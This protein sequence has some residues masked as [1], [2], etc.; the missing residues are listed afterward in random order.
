MKLRARYIYYEWKR[1]LRYI[2]QMFLGAIVLVFMT[3]TIAFCAVGTFSD[4][5]IKPTIPVGLVVHDNSSNISFLIDIISNMDS[6]KEHFRFLEMSLDEATAALSDGQICAIMILPN[7]VVSGIMDGTN[8][9]I[10]VILSKSDPLSSILLQEFATAGAKTL[11]SA[12]AGTYT[13]TDLYLDAGL[14]N[15]LSEAYAE[16]DIRNLQY[17]LVRD[18]LFRTVHAEPTGNVSTRSY[19][20]SSALIFFFLMLG[21]GCVIF[22]DKGSHAGIL[23]RSSAKIGTITERLANYLSILFY[24][25]LPAF[26]FAI[27]LMVSDFHTTLT[28]VE[29]ASILML[30][31]I[32]ILASSAYL[33]FLLELSTTPAI[34]VVTIFILSMLMM[35]ISGCFIP[36]GLLP[37]PLHCVS[38]VL[39]VWDMMRQWFHILSFMDGT[40]YQY[41]T[42][43]D[44][45]CL[46]LLLFS[47]IFLIA[48]MIIHKFRRNH[49]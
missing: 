33:F 6:A 23:K 9:H 25:L 34:S 10:Q 22:Y 15:L 13:M 19:Y 1:I 8:K 36:T 5:K 32:F 42:L 41:H 45:S 43:L 7:E 14:G 16:L 27:F 4:S 39:P 12:Q 47:F 2:P 3:G 46:K 18:D 40:T 26:L 37:A 28:F 21:I 29:F 31:L 38:N 35:F 44:S 11:S 20:L 17:A 30:L 48:G 24:Q 49:P